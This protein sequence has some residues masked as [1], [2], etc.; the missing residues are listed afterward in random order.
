MAHDF[1]VLSSEL[2]LDAPIVAVRQD[3]LA[4]PND[5][6]AFRE[7]IEHMGAVAVVAV[8]ENNEIA[9]VNQ[10]R[11]SVK[12][13]LWEIPAGLLDVKD[14]SE[15]LGAQREL[16][17][18]A[19][20]EATE[21]SVLTDLVTS[22]GFCEESARVFLAQ[23]LTTVE[24]PEAFGDEEADMDFAWV[25][26]DDAVAKILNGEINNSIAVAGILA[27]KQVLSGNGQARE[28]SA[29]FELRPTSIASRR[30][31]PDLKKQ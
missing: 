16:V 6:V 15:I 27:A 8:N 26:L 18:E 31:G 13:R 22:P 25:D 24:R 17:E 4:M 29:P 21:W 10:Y 1:K 5:Q 23:G 3:K 20:L 11:H 30:Q 2:L 9:M 7:V 19:G 28:V 12:R 14:E